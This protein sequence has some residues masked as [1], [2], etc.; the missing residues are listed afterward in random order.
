MGKQ[1]FGRRPNNYLIACQSKVMR[2]ETRRR[3]RES[4]R[5]ESCFACRPGTPPPPRDHRGRPTARP[6]SGWSP[7]GSAADRADG[8]HSSEWLSI[9][10]AGSC[11]EC[12]GAPVPLRARASRRPAPPCWRRSVA[13]GPTPGWQRAS[14]SR[15]ARPPGRGSTIARAAARRQRKAPSRLT[16]RTRRHSSSSRSIKPASSPA[17]PKPAS[18]TKASTCPRIAGRLLQRGVDGAFAGDIAGDETMR[19]RRFERGDGGRPTAFVAPPDDH[20]GARPGQSLRDAEADPAGPTSDDRY[21]SGE[22]CLTALDAHRRPRVQGFGRRRATQ[23]AVLHLVAVAPRS[24]W[25]EVVLRTRGRSRMEASV[26]CLVLR[27]SSIES[28]ARRTTSSRVVS[29]G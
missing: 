29:P 21:I 24:S 10:A 1:S 12:R 23:P 26:G 7:I 16:A 3:R 27:S 5:C 14:R 2:C 28:K 13:G 9:L 8:R 11:N 15:P 17:T 19:S 25:L 4:R 20:R 18:T 22:R 6:A